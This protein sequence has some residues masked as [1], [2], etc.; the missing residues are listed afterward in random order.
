MSA[1]V[2]LSELR[3]IGWTIWDPI[4]LIGH[5]NLGTGG[6][7]VDEYDGYLLAAAGKLGRGVTVDEVA[8]Y[9]ASSETDRM[10]L[11]GSPTLLSRAHATAEAIAGLMAAAQ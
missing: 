6:G 3:C 11:T 9:L 8:D 7:P 2:K 10:G 4:G 5:V 1:N